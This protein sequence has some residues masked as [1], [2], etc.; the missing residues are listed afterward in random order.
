MVNR[1]VHVAISI[2]YVFVCVCVC[3]KGREKGEG[4]NTSNDIVEKRILRKLMNIFAFKYI[5]NICIKLKISAFSRIDTTD[6]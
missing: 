5:L 2:V 4:V 6:C 3:V 1:R